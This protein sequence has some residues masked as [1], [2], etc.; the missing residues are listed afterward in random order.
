[1][2]IQPKHLN[3]ATDALNEALATFED[4]LQQLGFG[5]PA[6]VQISSDRQLSYEKCSQH[7]RL[8]IGD[9]PVVSCSRTARLMAV[10]VLPQLYEALV[11]ATRAELQRVQEATAKVRT[12]TAMLEQLRR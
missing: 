3:E 5:V 12:L 8:C 4:T 2:N 7:F 6:S 1:M 9:T 11:E 10:A